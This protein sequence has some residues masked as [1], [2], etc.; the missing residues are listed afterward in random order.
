MDV[1]KAKIYVASLKDYVGGDMV[2]KWFE[3]SD[4]PDGETLE[5]AIFDYLDTI[6]K[7]KGGD[8]REEFIVLDYEEFPEMYYGEYMGRGGFDDVYTFIEMAE[9]IPADALIG[10]VDYGHSLE[11]AE[12]AYY[13]H[14]DNARHFGEEWVD[15]VGGLD[16]VSDAHLYIRMS[17]TDKRIY[18][19]EDA[20]HRAEDMEIEDFYVE[21]D[22]EDEYEEG[23]SEEKDRLDQQ[24]R[25]EWE[26][27]YA[28]E[29]MESLEDPYHYFVEEQGMYTAN[30]L[31]KSNIVSF[32]YE[33]FAQDLL[34]ND[35]F[36]VEPH[37]EEFYVF[38][39]HY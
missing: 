23:Y 27:K 28:G 35:Y 11:T 29:V 8:K 19:G 14:F 4:Y 26:E 34:I 2:G 38:S 17:D 37:F 22:R 31:L 24:V 12:D 7:E 36:S 13:G 21:M 39:R 5:E 1:S 6:Q 25:E 3:F 9:H 30:E 15:S 10:Y 20:Y 16:G 33:D 32:D 18:A